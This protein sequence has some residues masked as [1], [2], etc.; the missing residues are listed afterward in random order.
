MNRDAEPGSVAAAGDRAPLAVL[1]AGAWGTVLAALL[2]RVHAVLFG[3]F[4]GRA[5]REALGGRTERETRYASAL[6]ERAR[7][8]STVRRTHARRRGA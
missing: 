2:A 3:V 7:D 5:P 4:G 1:G 6:G 8:A